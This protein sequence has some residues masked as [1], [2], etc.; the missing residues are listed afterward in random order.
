MNPVTLSSPQTFSTSGSHTACATDED[1]AGNVSE[2]GCLTVQVDATPPS[3]EI[4]CP[5]KALVGSST[6]ASY[7]ASDEYSGLSSE[8]SGT[9]PIETSTAGEKTVSTTAISNVGLQTTKSCS[10]VVEYPTPGAPELTVGKTPNKDGLFTLGWTG[11]NP[12]TYFGLSYTLQHQNHSGTWTTVMS[13]IEALSYEFSGAGEEEGT[14]VY[15]VQGSD[16]G[17]SQTTEYS[18]SSNPVVV[19][20]TAPYAPTVKASRAPDY[21]GGGGWYRNSRG[22][23]VQ[24]KRRSEP[25]GREPGER[26]Q[27]SVD[28]GLRDVQHVWLAHGERHR[29][30]QR[31]QRI[32]TGEPDGAG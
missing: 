4:S 9:I 32:S 14:W 2:P 7:M 25:V 18:P 30:G 27:P 10:T 13:G 20:K 15:R 26:R 19:D 29:E 16:P 8:E 21:A 24:L 3:L 1:F 22:S 23:V 17:H 12:M 6:S 28:P 11:A 31:R 5:A